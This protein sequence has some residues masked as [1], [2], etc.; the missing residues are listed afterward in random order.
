MLTVES[1]MSAACLDVSPLDIV[2]DGGGFA[3]FDRVF[4]QGTV[5]TLTAEATMNGRPLIA[6]QVN[7]VS[8]G[9]T[10]TTRQIV[11]TGDTTTARAIYQSMTSNN[12]P[13]LQRRGVN[14]GPSE[15]Q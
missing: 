9:T 8:I 13:I 5:V 14:S 15:P 6:W 7:G 10:S 3:A 11:I 4:P 1:N 12:M 2:L